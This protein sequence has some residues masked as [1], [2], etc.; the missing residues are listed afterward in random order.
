M[1]VGK[2]YGDLTPGQKRILYA[3]KLWEDGSDIENVMEYMKVAVQDQPEV[4]VFIDN[5]LRSTFSYTFA[6]QVPKL[7]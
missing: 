7:L 2:V 6:E 1:I 3:V 4:D 5:Q